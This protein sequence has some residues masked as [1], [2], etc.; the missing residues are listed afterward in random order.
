MIAARLTSLA[1][2]YPTP[3]LVLLLALTLLAGLGTA[4][5]RSV[6][7]LEGHL[8]ADDPQLG[9][10]QRL[11]QEFGSDQALVFALGCGAP[12]PCQSV[13]EPHVLGLIK[14]LSDQAATYPAVQK[15]MSLTQSGVLVGDEM[16]LHVE[17][18]DASLEPQQAPVACPPTYRSSIIKI[19]RINLAYLAFIG[20]IHTEIHGDSCVNSITKKVA[21]ITH[22]RWIV[23]A[24]RVSHCQR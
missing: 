17:R 4:N 21:N 11:V 22:D 6:S 13:F 8:P 16:S 18:L 19:D 24:E 3:T 15:V 2:R 12:R 20:C 1:L 23:G 7:Y 10:Y 5:L 9:H 14:T